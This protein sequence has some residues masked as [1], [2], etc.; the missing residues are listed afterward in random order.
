M[1]ESPVSPAC[2]TGSLFHQPRLRYSGPCLGTASPSCQRVPFAPNGISY[3]A[4]AQATNLVS[5]K[6]EIHLSQAAL[7]SPPDGILLFP[8][9]DGLCVPDESLSPDID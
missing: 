8:K 7:W 1:V 3:Q 5:I 9:L 6:H 4:S 2:R